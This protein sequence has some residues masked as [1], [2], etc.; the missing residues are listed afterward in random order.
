MEAV[1]HLEVSKLWSRQLLEIYARSSAEFDYKKNVMTKRGNA[2]KEKDLVKRRVDPNGE[3]SEEFHTWEV[4]QLIENQTLSPDDLSPG[5]L[6][7]VFSRDQGGLLTMELVSADEGV[8]DFRSTDE[9]LTIQVTRSNFPSIYA[10]DSTSKGNARSPFKTIVFQSVELNRENKLTRYE[11]EFASI[12]NDSHIMDVGQTNIAFAVGK[13]V[14]S[15]EH[16]KACPEEPYG[17]ACIQGIKIS[18]GMHNFGE[19]RFGKGLVSDFRSQTEQN[20]RVVGDFTKS[21]ISAPI[22]KEMLAIMSNNPR[23]ADWYAHFRHILDQ[24][25]EQRKLINGDIGDKVKESL[26]L[27]SKEAK[28]WF[29]NRLQTRFFETGDN[30]YLGMEFTREYEVWKYK[31]VDEIVGAAPN[32][33]RLK[34]TLRAQC[35]RLWYEACIAVITRGDVYN[36][37]GKFYVPRIWFIP[38][39]TDTKLRKLPEGEAFRIKSDKKQKYEVV[40]PGSKKVLVRSIEGYV[41]YL[42]GDTIVHLESDLTRQPDGNAE[43]RVSI[44][45]FPVSHYVN[46]RAINVQPSSYWCTFS[47]GD[48]QS[49]PHFMRYSGLTGAA[50]NAMLINNYLGSSLRL[51]NILSRKRVFQMSHETN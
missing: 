13:P 34:G 19:T 41:S 48:G 21:V 51:E 23:S 18:M 50:I 32:A 36:P 47:I 37:S 29:R 16:L 40:V 1:L 11:V 9:G 38:G 12:M 8:F 22:V 46:Y 35:D 20:T 31:I 17:V 45:T 43:S 39:Y 4:V 30:Y 26:V 3:P 7:N 15:T 42:S 28:H 44:A 10:H 27:L 14:A 25:P 24:F 33:G 49:S 6:Y 2:L 5:R